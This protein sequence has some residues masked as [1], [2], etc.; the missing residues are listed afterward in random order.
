M[1]RLCNRRWC[2]PE[3]RWN[4]CW[5][6]NSLW[7]LTPGRA[8]GC[9][10]SNAWGGCWRCGGGCRGNRVGLTLSC[11]NCEFSLWWW[12]LM[13]VTMALRWAIY[14]TW[15]GY[16]WHLELVNLMVARDLGTRNVILYF[17][18][19]R[20]IRITR[21]FFG[22]R[23]SQISRIL[24]SWCLNTRFFLNTNFTNKT[25]VFSHTDLTDLTDLEPSARCEWQ[26]VTVIGSLWLL[27]HCGYWLVVVIDLLCFKWQIK[28]DIR[29]PCEALA[30]PWDPWDPCAK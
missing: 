15:M 1:A 21:M 8:R 30:D 13:V 29:E 10:W 16:L 22:T 27:T 25:N 19:T 9:D 12:L 11:C 24:C 18:W 14:G 7:L 4:A 23:I 17:F 28:K 5:C 20:I 6:G 2:W 26:L 3:W